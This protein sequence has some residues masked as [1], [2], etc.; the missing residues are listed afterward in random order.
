MSPRKSDQDEWLVEAANALA[1]A[2][3]LT[4]LL[5]LTRPRQDLTLA[6]LQAEIMGL[7]REVERL[8]RERAGERRR[9]FHPQWMEYSVWHAPAR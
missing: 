8:Q 2:E 7:R 5:A 4:G 9:D 3:R 1:Q 6:T